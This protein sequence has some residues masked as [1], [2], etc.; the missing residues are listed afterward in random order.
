M[1]KT[2]DSEFYTEP[3]KPVKQFEKTENFKIPADL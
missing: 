2:I 1:E 3:L